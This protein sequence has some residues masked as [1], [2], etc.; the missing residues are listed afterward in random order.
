MP[1]YVAYAVWG[2]AVAA[3]LFVLVTFVGQ[4]LYERGEPGDSKEEEGA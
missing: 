1:A 3:V 2:L 4:R